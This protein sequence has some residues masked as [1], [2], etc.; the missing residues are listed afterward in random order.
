MDLSIYD[1][2][3]DAVSSSDY[4]VSN[5][6]VIRKQWTGNDVYGGSRNIPTSSY[7]GRVACRCPGR[8]LNPMPSEYRAA[9]LN[10]RNA[11]FSEID[12]VT[13]RSTGPGS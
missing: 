11:K 1:L 3:N 5:D 12:E 8:G 6:G 10:Q 7:R 2:F 9:R 4:A 13:T